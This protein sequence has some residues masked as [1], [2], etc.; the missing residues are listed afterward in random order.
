MMLLSY[1]TQANT[2][3][4]PKACY[5]GFTDEVYFNFDANGSAKRDASPICRDLSTPS[6][7]RDGQTMVPTISPSSA[8][9]ASSTY[10]LVGNGTCIS[11]NYCDISLC[12]VTSRVKLVSDESV[13]V[14]ACEVLQCEGYA[15]VHRGMYAQTCW[16]Y[17][18]KLDEGLSRQYVSGE[19]ATTE[20]Q[21]MRGSS[22][23]DGEGDLIPDWIIRG[24]SRQDTA[25][26]MLRGT[27]TIGGLRL[28]FS[29][30]CLWH[31]RQVG[32][33]KHATIM[34]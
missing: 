26:C 15:Y 27:D 1:V 13:C 18:K 28:K 12:K 22:F 10:V 8:P 14:D 20:W 32:L 16:V 33:G 30:A 29:L 24:P 34:Q 31:G 17:G 4:Y 7:T 6:P 25:R 3:D 19:L 21:G 9:E 2:P 23:L 5:V 11:G